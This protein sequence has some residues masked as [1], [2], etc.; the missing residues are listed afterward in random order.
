MSGAIQSAM[1]RLRKHETTQTTGRPESEHGVIV[2]ERDQVSMFVE[3]CMDRTN[4]DVL[5][6]AADA[7]S[8]EVH[9]TS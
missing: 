4:E 2:D 8:C 6:A 3:F 9:L 7:P 1:R 5:K